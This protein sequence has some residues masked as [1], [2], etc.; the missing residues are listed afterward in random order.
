MS[1][2]SSKLLFLKDFLEFVGAIVIG[3]ELRPDVAKGLRWCAQILRDEIDY[4]LI[5][6][7]F[8][9][10]LANRDAKTFFVRILCRRRWGAADIDCIAGRAAGKCDQF[11][12]GK[13]RANHRDVVQMTG[14]N[15]GIVGV[16][17]TSPGRS[18][19]AGNFFEHC[20]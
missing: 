11:A 17:I 1:S 15:P 19:S 10:D 8:L 5:L 2:K 7:T 13:D 9:D 14:A 18:E 16:T 12:G 6:A 20:G 4:Q 3:G